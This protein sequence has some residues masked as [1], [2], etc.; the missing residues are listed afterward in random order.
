[1]FEKIETGF[2]NGETYYIKLKEGQ[3]MGNLIFNGYGHNIL[4]LWFNVPDKNVCYVFKINEIDIYRYVTNEEFLKKRKEIY[5]CK[6]LNTIL[7][8]LIDDSFMW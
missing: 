7:K 6:C 5:H 4:N 3:I 8:R 2:V 1:M